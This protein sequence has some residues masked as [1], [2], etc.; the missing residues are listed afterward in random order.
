[1]T[2]PIV[3]VLLPVYNGAAHLAAAVDSVLRQTFTRFELIA[4]DDGST[5][6]SAAML[7]SYPA[8]C[9]VEQP[10]RGV[11]AARNAGL[12]MAR[13]E[14]IAFID[15]DDTWMPDKLA[16]QAAFLQEHP[17]VGVVTS[18]EEIILAPGVSRPAWLRP[19]ML[20]NPH[21]TY[22]PSALL[23]RR[24]VLD[25]VGR[26]GETFRCGSDTDWLCRARDQGV[27]IQVLPEV[28]IR[29]GVHGANESRQ[30]RISQSEI[31][32]LL[33]DSIRRKRGQ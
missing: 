13:G 3:S 20:A 16:R 9:L 2:D 14:F 17:G 8:V 22:V 4:V 10:N 24:A 30:V 6:G 5:D 21:P 32:S 28:L 19:E 33:R 18:H 29:K 23:I 12:N 7:R 25:E 1:M 15:Q 31:V 11:A 27:D 26:F